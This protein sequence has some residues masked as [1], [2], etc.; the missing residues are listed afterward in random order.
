MAGPWKCAEGASWFFAIR[1]QGAAAQ[2]CDKASGWRKV[3]SVPNPPPFP[4]VL[5]HSPTTHARATD[6]PAPLSFIKGSGIWPSPD[7]A[8][9]SEDGKRRSEKS[10]CKWSGSRA[11]ALQEDK[12][13]PERKE[14]RFPEFLLFL[15]SQ[16]NIYCVQSPSLLKA[17]YVH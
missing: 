8:H 12:P 2:L 6:G 9:L 11:H 5:P 3:L 17:I 10:V 1:N 13:L 14:K 7:R 4:K 15:V 16:K